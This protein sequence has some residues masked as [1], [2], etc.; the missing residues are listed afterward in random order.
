MGI[1]QSFPSERSSY[2]DPVSRTNIEQLTNWRCHNYHIYF[3]NNGFWDNGRRV[4]FG[5][6]RNNASNLFS[7]DLAGGEMTQLTDYVPGTKVSFQNAFLNPKRDEV[8]YNCMGELVALDLRS[9]KRRVLFCK[10]SGYGLGNHSV[11]AD[12]STVCVSV[13]QDLSDKIRM[14]L[15][16]GYI[17][18]HEYHAAKPHCM[19]VGVPVDGGRERVIFEDRCWLG[20]IN[21]S[22]VLADIL[23]FCHEGPWHKVDQRM[24][25]LN[26]AAGRATKLRPQV[27]GESMGHEYWFAD[28]VRV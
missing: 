16:N 17:G 28:G 4:L 25:L 22:P 26:I 8:Y 13:G 27:P 10:P 24:W 1:G 18:F 12:G 5:S 3:T 15:G 23:T 14:D 19:I 2:N 20:H 7:L 11:T 6:H 21:T 9:L